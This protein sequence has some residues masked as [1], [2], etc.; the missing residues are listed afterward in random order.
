MDNLNRIN[1]IKQDQVINIINSL[2]HNNNIKQ[3]IIFGSSVTDRCKITSDLDIAIELY[4]FDEDSKEVNDIA[5]IISK[6]TD[7]N[8]D[9]IFLNDEDIIGSKVE[10]EIYKKGVKVF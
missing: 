6:N 5:K 4:N 3:I 7:H 2:E 1:K 8:F 10:N 9:L